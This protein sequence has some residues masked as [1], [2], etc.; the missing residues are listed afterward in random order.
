[1]LRFDEEVLVFDRIADR[2]RDLGWARAQ[3][4]SRRKRIIKLHLLYRTL[5]EFSR[6]RPSAAIEALRYWS[7]IS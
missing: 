7:K 1:M 3:R 2:A 5:R 6:L 4:V